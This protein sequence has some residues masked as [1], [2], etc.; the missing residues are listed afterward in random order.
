RGT[1]K[2]VGGSYGPLIAGIQRTADGLMKQMVYGDAAG[3]TTAYS[4]D[5]RRR[6]SS[7]QTYR[8]PPGSGIWDNPSAYSSSAYDPQ[9][10]TLQLLLQDEDFLYDIVGN[11][12]EIRDW[13]NPD[14]WPDGAKPVTKKVQYDD[15]YRATRVDYQYVGGDDEWTSPFEYENTGGSD[16]RRAAPAPHVEFDKRILRQTFRY[17]WLGNNEVTDD[18]AHGFYD[19]SLG[20]IINGAD[21]PYQLESA[22]QNVAGGT[23]NGELTAEY[24][25]AGNLTELRVSREGTC[26]PTGASC[27]QVFDYEWDEVGRLVRSRRWDVADAMTA[28][29]A[30]GTEAADLRH[31]YDASDQRVIKRA[32]VGAEDRYTLYL[33]DTLELRRAQWGNFGEAGL[34]DCEYTEDTAVPD[35]LANGVRLAR[36]MDEIAPLPEV[37]RN[38]VHCVLDTADHL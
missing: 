23:H 5:Q 27:D 6:L 29:P 12:V 33:F 3:T 20:T 22:A 26:L 9:E 7:V 17:D 31:Y 15:L 10:P 32:T 1:V 21:K 13:R 38:R 18:D 2:T 30:D 34:Q 37:D 11:P 16:P 4:Y 19:R 36:G 35:V 8:G 28:T 24:D 25:P 14:E